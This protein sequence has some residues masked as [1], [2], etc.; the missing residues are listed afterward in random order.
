MNSIL[1][2]SLE[3]ERLLLDCLAPQYCL[4]CQTVGQWYC[5]DCLNSLGALEVK[6]YMDQIYYFFPYATPLIQTTVQQLK[7]FGLHPLPQALVAHWQSEYT[8]ESLKH[9]LGYQ[10][11]GQGV[12][13]PVPISKTRRKRRGYNQAEVLAKSVSGWVGWPVWDC[14]LKKEGVSMVGQN[15]QTREQIGDSFT[16]HQG[17]FQQLSQEGVREVW[18]IDDVITTG[19]TLRA[20]MDRVNEHLPGVKVRGLALAH[21]L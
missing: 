17:R 15:K 9:A 11:P 10:G 7:Y 16:G 18:V 21:E 2:F 3:L 19:S 1:M 12:L 13:M 14:L 5:A 4:G 8:G 6:Q 20:C